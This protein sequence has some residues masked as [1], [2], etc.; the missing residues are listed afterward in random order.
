V[1]DQRAA[2][3][4]PFRPAVEVPLCRLLGVTTVNEQQPQWH[5]PAPR[6]HRRLADNRD[7]VVVQAGGVERVSQRRQGVEP[8]GGRID[9]GGVVVLPAR[10]VLL[11]AVVVVHRVDDRAGLLGGRTEQHRGFPAV[12][13]DFDT[14][15]VAQVLHR[16]VVEGAAFVAG[17]EA[18]DLV[19]EGEQLGGARR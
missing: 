7:D 4:D 10:L 19:G 15:A 6:H 2:D 13:T 12:R 1:N 8:A 9:Q 14:D 3:L 17:H 5:S 16:S 18:G 11:R